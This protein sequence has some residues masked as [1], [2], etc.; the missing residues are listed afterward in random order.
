MVEIEKYKDDFRLD[1]ISWEEIREN[2]SLL[3][4]AMELEEG[5][6]D[7][8]AVKEPEVCAHILKDY[9]NVDKNVYSR[10]INLIYSN[11]KV[12]NSLLYYE[13]EKYS[14]LYMSLLNRLFGLTE[15]QKAYA[16]QEAK[17]NRMNH[18]GRV[19]DIR[20][21]ILKNPNWEKD[22][23]KKLIYDF[24]EDEYDFMLHVDE[25]ERN[26]LRHP[27]NFQNSIVSLMQQDRLYDYSL[28]DL[29]KMYQN[30]D[31]AKEVFDEINFCRMLHQVRPIT[32]RK[33]N[34]FYKYKQKN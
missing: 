6:E 11:E 25:F 7:G 32:L 13:N 8:F 5:R 18:G 23:K 28:P 3:L 12:A 19:C 4:A 31:V 1:N 2:A 14:F 9:D 24:Y 27:A 30:S 16:V 34:S 22:E 20:Y 15:M 26:V 17:Y 21:Q 33:N 10:L 29:E